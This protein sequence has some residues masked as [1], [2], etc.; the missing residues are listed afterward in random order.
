M[1][2]RQFC[3]SALLAGGALALTPFF[4]TV[5]AEVNAIRLDGKELSIPHSLVKDLAAS[6]HGSL[7]LPGNAAYEESR[8]VLNPTIDKYPALIIQPTQVSDVCR[9]VEFAQANRLV[10]AIKCGGHSTAGKS[11]VDGG[12]QIDLSRFRHVSVDPQ[13]QIAYVSGGSLQRA[14][15]HATLAHG[16]VTTAGTVS[17]TGIGGLATGGGLGRVG[18]K[19]GLTLDNIRAMDIVS[20]DGVLRHASAEEYSDLYWAARG[21]GSNFGVVTGFEFNLHPF[22]RYVLLGN[23]IYP[24]DRLKDALSFYAE[25]CTQAPDEMSTDLIYGYRSGDKDGF[26][27]FQCVYCG[28]EQEGRKL[29]EKF[30]VLGKPTRQTIEMSDYEIIQQSGDNNAPRVTGTYLRGGFLAEMPSSL[31]KLMVDGMEPDDRR[32]TIVLIQQAGG[33][34]SRVPVNATAFPHRYAQW[35]MMNIVGWNPDQDA[36]PHKS[37]LKRYSNTITP[38]TNGFYSVEAGDNNETLWNHNYQGNYARLKT[39][40]R[41]YDP[42]N[43]FRLNANIT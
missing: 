18:R 16:L 41:R 40:K 43:I 27:F 10:T 6:L 38:F 12:L 32:S 34:I 5:K 26:I 2:R 1:K 36:T 25:F 24:I 22:N 8:Q 11:T 30:S 19:Y 7:L 9:A 20:A 3:R 28:K 23:F 15:D 33:A 35:N 17:H 21:G 4:R 14:M 42:D 31:I 37:W 13:Q 39:I 29:L